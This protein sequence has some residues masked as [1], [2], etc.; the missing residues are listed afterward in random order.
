VRAY[1]AMLLFAP[2]LDEAGVQAAVDRVARVIA[3]RGGVVDRVNPW[4]KRRLAYEVDGH[5]EGSYVVL[6]F[7]AEQPAV[8]EL[9]RVLRLNDEVLRHIV[10][11]PEEVPAPAAESA[12]A[13]PA[14]EAAA[15]PAAAPEPAGAASAAEG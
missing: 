4:G 3:D 6:D 7:H 14:A 9:E 2:T 15:E 12:P 1:E 5:H 13:A 8:A 10:V 11:R